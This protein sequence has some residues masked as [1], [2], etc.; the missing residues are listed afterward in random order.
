MKTENRKKLLLVLA[1]SAFCIFAY[2]VLIFNELTNTY[3]GMWK[4]ANYTE[5][6][7][8]ISLGRWFW[9]VIGKARL[10]LS[11]EPFTSVFS[12]AMYILGGC[13]ILSVF[14]LRDSIIA[15]LVTLGVVINTAV[16]SALSYRY[17]APVFA[18][19]FLCS[20]LAV[21]LLTR[22]RRPIMNCILAVIVTALS[23]GSYQANIG[24]LCL[25]ALLYIT[26]LLMNGS[27]W[28]II[29]SFSVRTAVVVLLGCLLY[30]IIWDIIVN[31][32]GI[33]PSAYKGADSLSFRG[34]LEHLPERIKDAYKA[35]FSY[36]TGRRSGSIK[37][38]AYQQMIIYRVP[39]IVLF[40][41]VG[42]SLVRSGL[43]MKDRN[44]M[45]GRM[46]LSSGLLLLVPAAENF[47]MLV[48][49]DG[50]DTMIQM[51][52]PMAIQLP[53]L[54]CLSAS[55]FTGTGGD[56]QT[57]LKTDLS[58]RDRVRAAGV[59]KWFL[60]GQ[61]ILLLYGNTLMISIDQ[62]VMLKSRDSAVL[63]LNR[64]MS[65]VESQGFLPDGPESGYVF[66]G[67][68]SDNPQYYKDELWEYA[69]DYAQYGNF[70]LDGNCNTQSY[71]GLLRDS[72]IDIPLYQWSEVWHELEQR[73]NVREIPVFPEK[74]FVK[75]IDGAIV[76][77]LSDSE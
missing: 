39:M 40:L 5:Y 62:H 30:K 26:C 7:W 32:T 20:V 50:S 72:G 17:M 22:A 75:K 38:N 58:I 59:L 71:Y 41:S 61:M 12:L 9:P 1:V 44:R 69:N 43:L 55:L 57:D 77:R 27:S 23:L 34:I 15:C 4:G 60:Y 47:A 45:I 10:S 56:K 64:V 73:D 8:V 2:G 37:H 68:P 19:S 31:A 13:L 25:V 63:L 24:C 11:P 6:E 33:L 35:W 54:F 48:S 65:E 52:M 46:I 18:F 16:L 66:L 3:D 74:G 36:T 53:L 29:A 70:W 21:W 14:E 28:K 51:T 67:R 42:L 76:V 49:P